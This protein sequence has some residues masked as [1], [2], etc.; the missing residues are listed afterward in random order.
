[1]AAADYR[2]QS[3]SA[4][5]GD[6]GTLSP[7]AP[8][9]SSLIEPLF[10]IPLFCMHFLRPG[11]RGEGQMLCFTGD[12]TSNEARTKLMERRENN[13][14]L[15]PEKTSLVATAAGRSIP[16]YKVPVPLVEGPPPPSS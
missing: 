13:D 9:S 16:L 3:T 10:R 7:T 1:M 8:S 11:A 2:V 15:K 6:R 5:G 12:A 4:A 14:W